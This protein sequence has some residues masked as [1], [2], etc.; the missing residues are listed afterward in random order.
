MAIYGIRVVA[1][2]NQLGI[3]TASFIAVPGAAGLAIGLALQG[4]LVNFAA[5]VLT[6]LFKPFK[7]GESIEGSGTAGTVEEIQIFTSQLASPENKSII[8]PNAKMLGDNIVNCSSKGT[9]RVDLSF[10]P[11]YGDDIDPARKV[12][13]GIVEAHDRVLKELA[14]L[15]VV[16]EL[17]GGSVTLAVR[18]WTKIED[19]WG[20]YFETV[21]SVKKA[22]DNKGIS[23][24][25]PQRDVHLIERRTEA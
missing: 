12:I 9:R 1:A 21:K 18:A 17:A 7:R 20:F 8:V 25:F 5:G 14:P 3:Q 10:G 6:I 15:I 2:L 11:G 23:I 24:P 16:S 19:Y 13:R 22:F 4:S